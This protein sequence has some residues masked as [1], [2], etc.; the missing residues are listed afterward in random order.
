[1]LCYA[2]QDVALKGWYSYDAAVQCAAFSAGARIAPQQARYEAWLAANTPALDACSHV[3]PVLSTRALAASPRCNIPACTGSSLTA[4][5]PRGPAAMHMPGHHAAHQGPVMAGSSQ[6]VHVPRHAAT[7]QTAARVLHPQAGYVPGHA[8]DV[9]AAVGTC[10]PY[11]L[12]TPAYAASSQASDSAASSASV[13]A[14]HVPDT[15][16]PVVAQPW[17]VHTVNNSAPRHEA[18]CVARTVSTESTAASSSHEDSRR[19]HVVRRG[20]LMRSTASMVPSLLASFQR[21]SK[22]PRYVADMTSTRA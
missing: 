20:D 9:Q 15:R 18:G 12:H 1:M 16:R 11:T 6:A 4:D 10:T 21:H 5:T 17:P 22:R 2:D 19:G 3:A 8:A 13:F 7:D 14:A